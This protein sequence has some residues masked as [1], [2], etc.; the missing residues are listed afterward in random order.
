MQT[1]KIAFLMIVL[2]FCSVSCSVI[3]RQV[4]EQSLHPVSF[5][6]MLEY[7]NDY[8]GQTVILGGYI[9]A[10]ENKHEKTVIHVIQTPLGF[11]DY[12]DLKDKSEGRL[13]VVSREFLDPEIYEKDR[14]ITVAGIV[15]G[16]QVDKNGFCPFGCL[17]LESREIYLWPEYEPSHYWM[18]EDPYYFYRRYPYYRY[19]YDSYPY[20]RYR[21]PYYRKSYRTYPYHRYRSPYY[22]TPF[23]RYPDHW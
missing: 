23:W 12:P 10:T 17:K 6:A 21:W 11:M 22:R 18:D 20:Y 14:R 9:L 19:P 5:R 15:V 1:L 8:R 16:V 2:L 4:R 3:S 13:L 7:P